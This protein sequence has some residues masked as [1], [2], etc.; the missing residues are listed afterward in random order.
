MKFDTNFF[1]VIFSFFGAI[2][3]YTSICWIYIF[4]KYPQLSH[5]QKQ[6]LF[7]QTFFWGFAI[8]SNSILQLCIIAL[9]LCSVFYFGYLVFR[10]QNNSIKREIINISIFIIFSIFTLF[11]LWGIL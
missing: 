2:P 8:T 9:G 3:T 7:S 5:I 6:D 11:N 4:N 10:K 1:S